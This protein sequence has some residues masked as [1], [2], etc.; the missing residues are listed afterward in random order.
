VNC[1]EGTARIE[2]GMRVRMEASGGAARVLRTDVSSPEDT[3]KMAE[4]TVR[5]FGRIDVLVNCAAVV[6]GLQR[7]PSV[8]GQVLL[9]DRGEGY[10]LSH[11]GTRIA[12]TI[13]RGP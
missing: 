6:A 3:Q 12:R 13:K 10:A 5:V 7:K 8:T 1:F 2:T 11:Y 9:V 4:D